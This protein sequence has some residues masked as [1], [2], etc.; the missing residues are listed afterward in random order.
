MTAHALVHG[1]VRLVAFAPERLL[2]PDVRAVLAKVEVVA[3]PVLSKGYPGQRAAHVE[4]ELNDGKIHQ[5]FQPFRKGDPEMPLTDDEVNDKFLELAMPVIGDPAARELLAALWQLE[6]RPDAVFDFTSRPRAAPRARRAA[7][8]ALLWVGSMAVLLGGG[9]AWAAELSVKP[10]RFILPF[11][12][13]GGTD[14]LARIV[15]QR[16]GEN[17]GQTMVP[18]NRPGAGA[19]I[20]AEIGRPRA[21]RLHTLTMGNVAHAINMTLYAKPGYDLAR[22]FAP[23][24]HCSRRPRTSGRASIGRAKSVQELIALAAAG[25][26]Q[27][28]II[29]QRQLRAPAAELFK[30]MAGVNLTHVPYKGGGPAVTSLVGGETV[31]GFATAPSVLQHQVQPAA[32]ARGDHAKAHGRR[33]GAA[34]DCRK[35]CAELRREHLVWRAR[36]RQNGSADRDATAR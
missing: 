20:G 7:M 31:V 16:L 22:D 30:S 28:R 29:R 12:P 24:S 36:T 19:N 27:L 8:R 18:D 33:A 4:V 26:A 21:G 3:D 1:S 35:R 2:D 34:D 10:I 6:K 23:R 14:T 5:H 9:A 11:P 17:L 25:P 32:R 15:G 13:G